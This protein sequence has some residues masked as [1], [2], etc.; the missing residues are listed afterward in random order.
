MRVVTGRESRQTPQLVDPIQDLKFSPDW[1]VPP[2][3][4]ERDFLPRLRANP[5]A[6]SSNQYE[7]RVKSVAP[8]A[9]QNWDDVTPG[10][11][12]IRQASSS[13]GPLG[14]VRFSMYN[15]GSIFLHDTPERRLF[16]RNFRAYSSGCIRVQRAE[17]LTVWILSHQQVDLSREEV[18]SRMNS[19]TTSTVPLDQEIEV[20][21]QY[22]TA[23]VDGGGRLR[24]TDDPY[25]FDRDL[26]RKMGLSI[27]SRRSSA[28]RQISYDIG[29]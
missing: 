11:V 5:N 17:D 28:P 22:M 6:F 18:R 7:I 13:A 23:Y 4:V 8:S 9:I 1:T 12:F 27:A 21:L 3:V 10:D 24:F 19:G 16:D 14:G 15:S 20:S 2:T 26:A 25:S 29:P